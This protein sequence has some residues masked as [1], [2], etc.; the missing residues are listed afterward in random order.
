MIN[1]Y[2]QGPVIS[3]TDIRN[4]PL[5]PELCPNLSFS[6]EY[7]FAQ[8]HRDDLY[9]Y[10][11]HDKIFKN[12]HEANNFCKG[13]FGKS[14]EYTGKLAFGHFPHDK[15]EKLPGKSQIWSYA[16]PA[17]LHNINE[18]V[19]S[20]QSSHNN[21]FIKLKD[22]SVCPKA[23]D[24]QIFDSKVCPSEFNIRTVCLLR[25]SQ[26]HYREVAKAMQIFKKN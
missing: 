10:S 22:S 18:F 12:V 8:A 1:Q 9:C 15:N 20:C 25:Y 2:L 16:K 11:F 21:T 7:K 24:S 4:V 26:S 23:K 17:F 5:Q 6:D 19:C 3:P 14:E 13:A